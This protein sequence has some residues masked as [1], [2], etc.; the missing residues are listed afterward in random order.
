M[1]RRADRRPMPPRNDDGR[2]RERGKNRFARQCEI[3]ERADAEADR[4]PVESDTLGE[5]PLEPSA[6][7]C[8]DLLAAPEKP[9]KPWGFRPAGKERPAA[10]LQSCGAVLLHARPR[11]RTPRGSSRPL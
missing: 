2:H 6:E 8:A 4:Q 11:R 9:P 3:A 7:S 5:L 10:L 1:E